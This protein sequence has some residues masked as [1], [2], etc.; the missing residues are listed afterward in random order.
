MNRVFTIIL[1]VVLSGCT[2]SKVTRTLNVDGTYQNFVI[3]SP[4]DTRR[5]LGWKGKFSLY[6]P[7]DTCESILNKTCPDGFVIVNKKDKIIDGRPH[8][9]RVYFKCNE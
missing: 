1:V 5:D 3:C 8:H 2:S 9:S 7:Y 6:N 4:P